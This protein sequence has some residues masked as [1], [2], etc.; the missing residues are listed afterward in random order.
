MTDFS[1]PC[2]SGHRSGCS[3]L[4]SDIMTVLTN[5]RSIPDM[6]AQMTSDGTSFAALPSKSTTTTESSS[7]GSSSSGIGLSTRPGSTSYENPQAGDFDVALFHKI[8]H[9]SATQNGGGQEVPGF[10]FPA[11]GSTVRKTEEVSVWPGIAPDVSPGTQEL[12]GVPS[13]GESENVI[14]GGAE[15]GFW[16]LMRGG[17]E[18]ELDFDAFLKSF[19]DA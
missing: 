2:D 5:D 4:R 15:S 9:L 10:S 13:S 1:P 14:E 19:G 6:I 17:R 18:D 12:L 8:Q 16:D 7:G 11:S 3:K